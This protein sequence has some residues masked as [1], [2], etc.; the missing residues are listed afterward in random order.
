MPSATPTCFCQRTGA[1]THRGPQGAAVWPRHQRGS[2]GQWG[3]RRGLRE[4]RPAR[5]QRQHSHGGP[6]RT[7]SSLQGAP[8]APGPPV[9]SRLACRPGALIPP[10]VGPS[11]V[12]ASLRASGTGQDAAGTLMPLPYTPALPHQAPTLRAQ[13][14]SSKPPRPPSPVFPH[15]LNGSAAKT[16]LQS[17]GAPRP[18]ATA[19]RWARSSLSPGTGVWPSRGLSGH[20]LQHPLPAGTPLPENKSS[21]S[22]NVHS[23]VGAGGKR[24]DTE[25]LGE[26][27]TERGFFIQM[28][29]VLAEEVAFEQRVTLLLRLIIQK[30]VSQGF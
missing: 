1:D 10:S 19:E 21:S 8:C 20:V 18:P 14:P 5:K 16:S 15:P 26:N 22:G 30:K 12:T 11:V 6:A 25:C 17:P 2:G 9:L 4:P 13:V 29:G 23:R 24:R 3:H 28:L 7:C 27:D